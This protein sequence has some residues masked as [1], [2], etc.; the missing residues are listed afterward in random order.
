M[1]IAVLLLVQVP[2]VPVLSIIVMTL[3]GHTTE[4]PEIM[5]AVV[6]VMVSYLLRLQPPGSV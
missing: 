4:G 2:L 5:G 1:A 6:P 3:P